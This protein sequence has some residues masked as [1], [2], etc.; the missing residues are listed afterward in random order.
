MA[1]LQDSDVIIA[2]TA[3]VASLTRQL[4]SSQP[5]AKAI[6]TPPPSC[7]FYQGAHASNE[8]QV[9]NPFS[10]LKREQVH[11]VSNYND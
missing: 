11:Y 7:D 9:G 10:Q 6:Y 5:T 1:E 2:L 8:C 3:Q 4:Q